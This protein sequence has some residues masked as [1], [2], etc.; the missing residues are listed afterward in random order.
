MASKH[1]EM[2]VLNKI[3][4]KRELPKVVDIFVVRFAKTGTLGESRPCYHCL[5]SLAKSHL[6]IKYVYYSTTDG[7]IVREKFST[8]IDSPLTYI[9]SGARRGL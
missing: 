7:F 4:K 1:A 5:M 6:R 2:D 3:Y 8:M 9:S